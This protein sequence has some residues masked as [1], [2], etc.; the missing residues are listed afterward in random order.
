MRTS[1]DDN[2][3]HEHSLLSYIQSVKVA[4]PHNTLANAL[5]KVYQEDIVRVGQIKFMKSVEFY[6]SLKISEMSQ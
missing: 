3:S 5:I 2:P 1:L 6:E 4:N